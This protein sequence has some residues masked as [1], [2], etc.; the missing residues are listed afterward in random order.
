MASING[1]S[2]RDVNHFVGH[3]GEPLCQGN[4]YLGDLKL[5]FWSQDSWGGPDQ[6]RLEPE[7]SKQLLNEAVIS[8]NPEKAVPYEFGERSYVIDYDLEHLLGDC[9]E[10]EE[11][12]Q[13][14]QSAVDAGYSGILLAT[15]GY[16]QATW[17]LPSSYT[18]LPDEDILTK[19]EAGINKV[20]E[21][22]LKETEYTQHK[23]KVY[24][25]LDDFVVGEP[26]PLKEITAKKNLKNV[27]HK[28][29]TAA[30]QHSLHT[31]ENRNENQR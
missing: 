19:L 10:L 24:R 5:G 1:I 29:K 14:F 26:I 28:A 9:I 2:I 13:I 3:E 6:F 18:Q 31:Q 7:F 8:R 21:S 22:F 16:H 25:S 27:L 30:E 12:Q 23:L 15:D 20:K 4:L 17:N 11:D